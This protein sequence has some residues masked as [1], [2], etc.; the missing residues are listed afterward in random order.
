[1][2]F[3]GTQTL[4]YREH[5]DEL[6]CLS[7]VLTLLQNKDI[8]SAIELLIARQDHLTAEQTPSL[9]IY[10]PRAVVRA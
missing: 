5:R 9:K 8:C 6:A 1:M 2:A 3:V 4:E 10:D 7:R